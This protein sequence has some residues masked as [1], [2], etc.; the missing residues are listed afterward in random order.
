[1]CGVA[2]LLNWGDPTTLERMVEIQRHRGPDDGG[3]EWLHTRD[4][5][6]VGL[7]SRRLAIQ[8]LSPAGHMPMWN[9]E[10][11]LCIVYNGEVYN[12]LEL[13]RELIAKGYTFR[14]QTDTEVLLYLYQEQGPEFVRR[15]NGMF[16]F[17]LWDDRQ[18]RL[19]VARDPFGIKPLYYTAHPSRFACAS[20]MKALLQIPGIAPNISLRALHQYLTF[21]WVPEPDTLV[22]GILKLPAGHYALIQEGP[23]I[24]TEYWDLEFP[25][26]DAG[27]PGSERELAEEVRSRFRDAVGS[28][29]ISDRPVGAFLSAGIDSAS[30]VAT[31][32]QLVSE[33]LRTYTV[34]FPRQ[35]RVGENT[36]DDPSVAA[37]AAR[38]LNCRHQEIVIE[39]DVATLLPRL[40]WHMDEPVS[41]PAII[42]AYSV[43]RHATDGATVLLS[44]IG[45]D[46]LFAGYRKHCAHY[47]AKAYRALPRVL[48]ERIIRR[49]VE[50]MPNL[51]GSRFKGLLRQARKMVRSGS[52]EE[53]ERF[54]RD[55][56]YVDS[57]TT[58][59]LYTAE[60]CRQVAGFEPACRHWEAFDKVSH[61][62]FLNQMLYVDT[63]LFMTSL[64]LNYNDK[65]SMA[66]SI[67]VRVPFLDKSFAEFV[68]QRVPPRWK[69]NGAWK[70]TTKY[71]LRE[72]M[73]PLVPAE[74]FRQPKAGFAAPIDYWLAYDL[75]EMVDDLLSEG[76]V[77]HR[78]WFQ[79]ECVQRLIREHRSGARDWSYQLWQLLT[80]ELWQQTFTDV[81]SR[82]E[83]TE[84]RPALV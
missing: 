81:V 6:A 78:G 56:V 43:C 54:I 49:A 68:A 65:M 15:L 33:R 48:R 29:L 17:A 38:A 61:A 41:D 73:R 26:R 18:Q 53:R 52:L 46:E 45:G 13:R 57:G 62:D 8:D 80:L 30:I 5:R 75:R 50:A 11:T 3:T 12:F 63:K 16:A 32:S 84:A 82:P 36:L 76:R 71:L 2:A 28:Q 59:E 20:E 66:S 35:Y 10:R 34:T 69:L 58:R 24:L 70:T 67:E 31:A 60:L 55:S 40:V 83:P 51:H 77:R 14:S 47:W 22:E 23:P 25:E 72:A 42:A 1:M 19:M 79:P 27:Y 74:V 9:A 7:G 39:P 44:G 37:R 21:L 4:G 64:N